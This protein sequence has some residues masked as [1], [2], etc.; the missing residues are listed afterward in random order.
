MTLKEAAQSAL[1]VQNACNPS[2][3]IKALAG[4]VLDALWEQAN[5]T[6]SGSRWVGNHPIVRMYLYKIGELTGLEANSLSPGYDVA[7][8]ACQTIVKEL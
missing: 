2:G 8:K 7:E 1:D 6:G 4:P 3:V 5:K